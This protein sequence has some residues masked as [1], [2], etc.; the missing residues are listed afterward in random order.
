MN[1]VSDEGAVARIA[2]ITVTLL[3]LAWLVDYI[4]RLLI[5]LALPAIG[6]DFSLD[7]AEQGLILTVF[8]L[9]YALFQLPGGALADKIGA[10]K[11]MTI[12]LVGW[13]IF[14]GLTA[15]AF[16]HAWLLV[17][18]AIFGVG[19]GI[20]PAASMKVI[21]ERTQPKHR[22]TANGLMLCSNALGAADAFRIHGAAHVLP[23]PVAASGDASSRAV[24]D[25]AGLA[26]CGAAARHA[27][28][29][30]PGAGKPAAA[31]DDAG[32][33]AALSGRRALCRAG[34]SLADP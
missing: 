3:F 25:R 10:R 32:G 23:E 19:E 16:S 18:R 2:R 15:V 9:T 1:S 21:T 27:G 26:G 31:A 34:L 4:D 28:A 20:F 6:R 13:S 30:A 29:L 33:T 12:P 14:T 5:T 22:L 17:I 11:T 24:L 7:K 8:F